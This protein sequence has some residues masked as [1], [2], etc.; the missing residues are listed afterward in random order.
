METYGRCSVESSELRRRIV[1]PLLWRFVGV[2]SFRASV[3]DG[4][5]PMYPTGAPFG[6]NGRDMATSCCGSSFC[7]IEESGAHPRKT[8][9]AMKRL[10]MRYAVA[11][12]LDQISNMTTNGLKQVCVSL[13]ARSL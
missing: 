10:W 1:E 6:V 12:R 5:S 8:V 2:S 11:H 13:M 3:Y 9:A 7:T 4:G